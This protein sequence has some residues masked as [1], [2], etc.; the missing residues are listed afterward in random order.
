[1]QAIYTKSVKCCWR[2]QTA[3]S[4]VN[5]YP[6]SHNGIR[7]FV[8]FFSQQLSPLQEFNNLKTNFVQIGRTIHAHPELGYE[9][10]ETSD[11]IAK[12]LT[13]L[14]IEVKR[15]IGGTGVL[16]IF[17]G[18]KLGKTALLR[19]D[20]DRLQMIELNDVPYKSIR[21]GFMHGCGHDT[22]ATRLLGATMILSEIKDDL[23]GII[24]FIFHPAEEGLLRVVKYI[25]A[26]ILETPP[27]DA[28]FEAHL[29]SSIDSA[30]VDIRGLAYYLEKVPGA[31]FFVGT[32]N[33][34]KGSTNKLHNVRFNIDEDIL[35]TTSALFAE[36]A[37]QYL[38][39]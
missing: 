15:N 7:G 11:L 22:H 34:E 23:Q 39:S 24:K 1:M 28:A 30:R 32:R 10:Y 38:N 8:F 31:F 6:R 3:I 29:W 9:E 2:K 19:S 27:V 17:R 12:T 26:G 25:E 35:H 20:M 18:S 36:L 4:T 13:K 14:R 16:G 33:E 5:I 21:E 37:V